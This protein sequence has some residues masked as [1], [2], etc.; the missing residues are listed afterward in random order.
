MSARTRK[1]VSKLCAITVEQESYAETN[2]NSRLL[3]GNHI[4]TFSCEID[5]KIVDLFSKRAK[6]RRGEILDVYQYEDLPK[7]LRVQI[8]HIMRDALGEPNAYESKTTE[9]MKLI[10]DILCR[11]YGI[12]A[13]AE[14]AQYHGVNPIKD[15]YDHFLNE[16]DFEKALDVVELGFRLIDKL[17]R[18]YSFEK[19]SKPNINPDDAINELNARMRYHGVG[20]QFESGE[21][22]RVDDQV[23]HKEAVKPALQALS[24]KGFEGAN[25]EFLKA[26]EH[27]R[28]GRTKEALNEALKAFESTMK[29]ICN[30]NG[31]AYDVK[32]TASKLIDHCM[33]N[34]LV[35]QLPN[36]LHIVGRRP[37][38]WRSDSQKP[39]RRTWT[40]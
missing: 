34:N 16:P 33:S 10:H 31:W 9:Y 1:D 21:L 6:A 38:V 12:F 18:N 39:G 30:S 28:H 20:F 35:P 26:F 24:A 23:I 40:G 36:A 2:Q 7:P 32:D 5:M 4:N 14:N 37:Q 19:Y 15:V 17:C 3:Y 8:V 29:V 25:D 13:L 11:E 22:I 27:Y